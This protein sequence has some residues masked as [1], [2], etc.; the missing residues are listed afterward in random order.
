M[1]EIR[2]PTE[3]GRIES[4]TLSPPRDFPKATPPF[5]RVALAAAHVVAD[6]L[7][8]Q[9]PWLDVKVDWEAWRRRWTPPSAAWA[10]TGRARRS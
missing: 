1:P 9:D 4:F 3:E 6:P 7:A 5:P 8:E 10:S 2:L